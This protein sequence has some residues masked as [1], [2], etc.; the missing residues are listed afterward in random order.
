MEC[1]NARYSRTEESFSRNQSNISDLIVLPLRRLEQTHHA[2]CFAMRRRRGSRSRRSCIGRSKWFRRK[3]CVGELLAG[4]GRVLRRRN[5]YR[6]LAPRHRDRCVECQGCWPSAGGSSRF[7]V[8][9]GRGWRHSGP[10]G[11]TS[12]NEGGVHPSL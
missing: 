7:R 2:P 10:W 3:R 12:R 5:S 11:N 1:K 8:I 6:P 9:S 4:S